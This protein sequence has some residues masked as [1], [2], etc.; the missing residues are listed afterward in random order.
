M[1]KFGIP[2]DR[3]VFGSLKQRARAYTNKEIAEDVNESLKSNTPISIRSHTKKD[4]IKLLINVYDEFPKVQIKKAWDL[5]IYGNENGENE[6][7]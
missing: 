3:R 1:T 4:S 7:V 6:D 5:A 2:L